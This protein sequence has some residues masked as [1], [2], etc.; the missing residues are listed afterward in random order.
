MRKMK[1]SLIILFALAAIK[2][3]AQV[4]D[5]LSIGPIIGFGH[6]WVS[7]NYNPV[8]KPSLNVGGRL[9]YS[10]SP[11]L[12]VGLDA[13]FRTEGVRRKVDAISISSGPPKE[14]TINYNTNYLRLDPKLFYF[15]ESMAKRCA[16]SWV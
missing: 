3:N 15:L 13:S 8:F 4:K 6:S 1:L 16:L 9:V 2:A 11:K 12:G 5:N 14:I 10:A 7:N